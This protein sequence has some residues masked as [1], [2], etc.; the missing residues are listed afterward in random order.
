MRVLVTG[1]LGVNGS[2]VVRRLLEL[3]HEPVIAE[4]R[5]DRSLISDLPE[6]VPLV[7]LDVR[8]LSAIR[9]AMADYQ[10]ERVVHMAGI[11]LA[12]Q[13]P[14]TA[15][16][17]N[18]AGTAA[19]CQAAV[20][21]GIDRVVF[22]SSRAVY[23]NITGAHAHPR[24]TPIT[25]EHAF[26][27]AKLYD[28]T[29]AAGESV[30]RWYA[31]ARGLS[32]VALRFATIYG[33]GKQ[34]RHGGVSVYSKLI[35]EPAAGRPVHF[36]RGGDQ[37]DDTIYV[38]DVADAIV[39]AV[40]HPGPRY[41]AYNISSGTGVT[42]GDIAAA[43]R[44]EIPDADITIGP[45]LDPFEVGASYYGVLDGSRAREDLGWSAQFDLAAGVRDYLGALDRLH[46]IDR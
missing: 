45:G 13:A 34:V 25:E 16:E 23:G 1:G 21:S 24:Y 30:G 32:W 39:R 29:K 7:E 28:V 38:A 33:P 14:V 22:T 46:L 6:E 19:V 3:G 9:Q 35:E 27:P 37:R 26:E 44:A 4:N 10:V 12:D 31:R 15:V 11:M 36:E 17:V 43:V 40:T 18:V 2:W 42:M 5:L 8:D 20:D 41:D